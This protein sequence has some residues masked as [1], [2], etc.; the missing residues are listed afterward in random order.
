MVQ[1]LMNAMQ[2]HKAGTIKNRWFMFCDDAAS[3][4]PATGTAE[5]TTAKCHQNLSKEKL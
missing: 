2:P 1:Y 5:A 3:G 4:P